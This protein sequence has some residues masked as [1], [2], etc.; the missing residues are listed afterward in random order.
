MEEF[1]KTASI[2]IADD[3]PNNLK[4]LSDTL[5]GFGYEVRV[6]MN[7]KAAVDSIQTQAPDLILM[8]IHMPEMDGLEAT[9]FIRGH[10]QK[11]VNS[12][13]PIIAMTASGRAHV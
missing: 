2:L 4:V 7:G 10:R 11:S 9:K 13:I 12:N 5:I 3:N 6:A 8:D 1:E